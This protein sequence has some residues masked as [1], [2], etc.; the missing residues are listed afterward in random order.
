[1]NKYEAGKYVLLL[2]INDKNTGKEI[3][4]EKTLTWEK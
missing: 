1:M 4:G 2:S 3:R